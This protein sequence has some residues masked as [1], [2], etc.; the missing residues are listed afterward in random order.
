MSTVMPEK[1][2]MLVE[3]HIKVMSYDTDFMKIVN[4]TVYVKWF[5]DLRMLILDN[6]FPFEDMLKENQSPILSETVIQYKRPITL[7]SKPVA[8]A[9]IESIDRS[10][11]V[12]RFEIVENDVIYCFGKQEGYYFDLIKMRPTRFPKDFIDKFNNM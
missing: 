7:H 12:A 10:K 8:K 9:W 6:Y 1:R 4:N 5:E 3:K 11:W 2:K